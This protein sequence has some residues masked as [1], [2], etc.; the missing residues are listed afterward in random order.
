MRNGSVYSPTSNVDFPSQED[1]GMLSQPDFL[2]RLL[3]LRKFSS[4][5]G[6]ALFLYW[7]TRLGR[8]TVSTFRKHSGGDLACSLTSASRSAMIFS[9][10]IL[11]STSNVYD[12]PISV[13]NIS[14]ILV[15]D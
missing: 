8:S 6:D 13:T 9:I 12:S 14:C 3:G 11:G 4:I 1:H 5:I 15:W 2:N 10:S 7:Y